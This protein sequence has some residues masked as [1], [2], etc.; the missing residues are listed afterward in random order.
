V[1]A[2]P[3]G[4]QLPLT[5][6]LSQVLV[7]FTIEFDNEFERQMPHRTTRHGST[8]GAGGR[9]GPWLVSMVMWS[10]CMQYVPDE[11][12]AVR[13]LARRARI[14]DKSMRLVLTRMGAWWGY[15]AVEPPHVR[16][17]PAGRQA[18]QVWRPLTAMI[19]DRWLDRHG[20]RLAG[21]LRASLGALASQIDVDLP[22]YLPVGEPR[23]E[24]ATEPGRD[25]AGLALPVLLSRVLLAFA[26]D[27]NRAAEL[28]IPVSANVVRVLDEAGVRVRDV[29]GRAGVASEAAE[30]M[31]GRLHKSGH[32]VVGPDPAVKGERGGG[33]GRVARLTA[34]GAAA[35]RAYLEHLDVIEQHWSARAGRDQVDSLRQ[36]LEHLVG[37]PA[38]ER[39]PLLAGLQPYP[40]GWRASIAAPRTLPHYPL[41]LHRGGFPDG[42]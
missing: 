19:E 1:T 30:N 9:R 35:Q 32:V 12:I 34:K 39:P 8:A 23:L 29:A 20:S 31:L 10:N 15:L 14:T 5:A 28:P 13:E 41:V 36:V 7:A 18:Q 33:R 22:D 24:P 21:Q 37:D 40:G 42:S 16:P 11:G 27:F 26:L 17:T 38:A 2:G 6:L 3:A 25:A 4:E